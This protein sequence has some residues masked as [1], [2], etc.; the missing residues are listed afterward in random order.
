MK[1]AVSCLIISTALLNFSCGQNVES[2][3]VAANEKPAEIPIPISTPDRFGEKMIK[4]EIDSIGRFSNYE[5]DESKT[6]FKFQ[7]FQIKKE[8]V[9]RSDDIGS[10]LVGVIDAVLSKK[11]KRLARFE[12]VYWSLGNE[13]NFGL[14]PFL[15]G[16]EKQLLVT[17]ESLHY[18]HDWIVRLSPKFEVIYNN[19]D[20]GIWYGFYVLDIDND[21]VLELS[22]AKNASFDFVFS[23]SSEM[24]L[25]IIFR[26]DPKS[27]K[28]LPATHI[29]PELVLQGF[30]RESFDEQIIKFNESKDKFLP[31]FL[32]IFMKY[33]YG[34]REAEAWKFFDETEI[35]IK[36]AEILGGKVDGKQQTKDH[37]KKILEKDPIY[38][39]IRKDLRSRK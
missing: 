10:T 24:S 25:K 39:F 38:K 29:Y 32:Q 15:G 13:I 12:G 27:H 36:E 5:E 8:V 17:D 31:K 18:E 7:G 28:Y 26:Y 23:R 11:G 6:A 22:A 21:G 34:G 33:I 4:D 19:E 35:D 3:S 30:E 1:T 20:F 2:S 9:M 37:L 14:Y 16:A